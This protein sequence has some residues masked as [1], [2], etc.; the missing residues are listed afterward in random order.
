[1]IK[2]FSHKGLERF[3]YTGSKSGIIPEHSNKLER[4]LDRLN[5]ATD[6]KDMNY[7]GSFLHQLKRDKAGQFSVRVSGNWRVF[8]KFKNGDAY[9]VNYGDYH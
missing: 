9:I 3:F 5:A 2:T 7:P 1:M 8:F 6:I 4:I